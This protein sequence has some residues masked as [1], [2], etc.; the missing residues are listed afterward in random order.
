MQQPESRSNSQR[1][2]DVL[3]VTLLVSGIVAVL[4]MRL[5]MMKWPDE[6][7]ARAR[8]ASLINT[9]DP[10]VATAEAMTIISGI[11]PAKAKAIV[12]HRD[13]VREVHG[14]GVVVFKRAEDLQAVHGIGPRTVEKLRRWFHFAASPSSDATS[15]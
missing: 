10:N 1:R 7:V 4:L 15:N 5:D 2:R 6:Q 3:L 12:D 14:D 8:R 11:G 9:L 13:A